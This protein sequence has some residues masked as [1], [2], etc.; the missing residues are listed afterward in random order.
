MKFKLNEECFPI[1]ALATSDHSVSDFM[2]FDNYNPIEMREQVLSNE[3]IAERLDDS[4]EWVDKQ[5]AG[6]KRTFDEEAERYVNFEWLK[7]HLISIRNDENRSL[8]K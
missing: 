2:I 1:R 4:I 5:I 3:G 6:M 8:L 7:S